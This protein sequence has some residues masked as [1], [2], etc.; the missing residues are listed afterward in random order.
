MIR[1]QEIMTVFE[2][3]LSARRMTAETFV[4]ERLLRHADYDLPKQSASTACEERFVLMAVQWTR[5]LISELNRFLININY[6]DCWVRSVNGYGEDDRSG[7]I[8]EFAEPLLEL[9]VGRPYSV[10]N[11]FVFATAHLLNQANSQKRSNWTDHLPPDWKIG[12]DVLGELGRDWSKFSHFLQTLDR[13]NDSA[14]TKSTGNFRNVIQ[15]RFRMHFD[16]GLTPCIDRTE[17]NAGVM[18]VI[19]AFPPLNLD[20]LIPEL[21]EQ[22]QRALDVFRDYWQLVSELGQAWPGESIR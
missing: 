18:Y 17:T 10:K 7:I 4:R 1:D 12:Y 13:L 2:K 9:A 14:F 5:G 22:H 16:L 15:H 8:C 6:A 19:G 3:F 21:Y 11:Q 20:N